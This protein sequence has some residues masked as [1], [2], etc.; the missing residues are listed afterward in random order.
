MQ[1]VD[2]AVVHRAAELR[3]RMQDDR[4]RRVLFLL[5]VV[6]A[7]QTTFGTGKNDFG[8]G[9]LSLWR[10]VSAEFLTNLLG[11]LR[12]VLNRSHWGG[13]GLIVR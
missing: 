2:D 13:P 10:K 12:T 7:F 9:A 4:N 8:H 3:M 6:T 5:R 11:H 1:V